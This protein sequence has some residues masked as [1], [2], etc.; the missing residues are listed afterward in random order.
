MNT[1]PT[2]NEEHKQ[3]KDAI[4][5]LVKERRRLLAELPELEELKQT[6]NHIHRLPN[7]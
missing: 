4:L 5:K 3:R 2:T 6:L 1:L 7:V